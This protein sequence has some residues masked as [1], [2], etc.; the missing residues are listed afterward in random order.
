MHVS[1]YAAAPP[2]PCHDRIRAYDLL[3]THFQPAVHLKEER[4]GWPDVACY[5]VTGT[6][7]LNYPKP[8]HA[9]EVWKMTIPA[10]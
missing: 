8:P 5:G 7:L 3:R 4:P 9:L 1:G 10:L 6:Y 2:S